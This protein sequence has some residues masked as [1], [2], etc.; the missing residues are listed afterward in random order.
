MWH[1][2]VRVAEAWCKIC[3]FLVSDSHACWD[4]CYDGAGN[5][6][7]YFQE[8]DID[9]AELFITWS[10]IESKIKKWMMMLIDAM[11]MRTLD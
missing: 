6:Y 2:N 3:L 7:Q 5:H 1:Q 11:R 9:A 4:K 8:D 10:R